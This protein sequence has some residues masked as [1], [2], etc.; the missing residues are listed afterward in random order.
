MQNTDPS[1]VTISNGGTTFTGD[2]IQLFRAVT[3]KSAIKLHRDCG[4]IPTRGMTITKLFGIA[5]Q[6]TGKK[7]KRGQH[8]AA[9]ADLTVWID[10]ANAAMPI[11]DERT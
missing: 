6:I 4:M 9:I 8:D 11:I 3:L 7:Y 1:A 10:A 5:Q 2:G